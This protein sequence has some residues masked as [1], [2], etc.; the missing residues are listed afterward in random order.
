[1]V[2][3]TCQQVIH[4]QAVVD[5]VDTRTT[6]DAMSKDRVF[7]E[8]LQACVVKLVYRCT[9]LVW[10]GRLRPWTFTG[11]LNQHVTPALWAPANH[12]VCRHYANHVAVLIMPLN[13][14]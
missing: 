12:N 6:Q 14:T 2:C 1:M 11:L 10:F 4:D 5:T 3:K 13:V 8:I 9:V 7:T